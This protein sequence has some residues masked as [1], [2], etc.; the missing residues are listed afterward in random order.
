DG[1]PGDGTVSPEAAASTG[2]P[3]DAAH[4]GSGRVGGSGAPDGPGEGGPDLHEAAVSGFILRSAVVQGW[5]GMEVRGYQDARMTRPADLLRLER[6]ADGVLFA[7]FGQEV[8]VVSFSEPAET[9][10]FGFEMPGKEGDPYL[11]PLKYVDAPGHAPGTEM[12]GATVR[13]QFRDV[14]RRVVDVMRLQGDLKSTLLA[15]GGLA[16]GGEW[17]AAEFA[18]EMIQGVQQADF[19]RGG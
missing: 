16:Q 9:L 10:H 18:L 1:G 13:A 17:T 3:A 8:A 6:V 14:G 4:E 5:P 2:T 7:L 19:T 11:K 15:N 12:T